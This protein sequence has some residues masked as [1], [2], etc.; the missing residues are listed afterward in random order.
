MMEME[1]FQVAAIQAGTATGMAMHQAVAVQP[2]T[3]TATSRA[4][5]VL[6]LRVGKVEKE[7]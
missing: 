7:T 5:Q 1:I 2:A 6:D 3:G 4:A